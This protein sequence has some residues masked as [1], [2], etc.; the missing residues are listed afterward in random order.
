MKVLRRLASLIGFVVVVAAGAD[1]SACVLRAG[2]D[3]YG[4]YMYRDENGRETGADIELMRALADGAG[5]AIEFRELPWARLLRQIESGAIDLTASV[6][7]TTEREAYAHFSMPYRRTEMGVFV[8][9][10]E[11]RG[12]AFDDLRDIV[13][14]GFRLGVIQDYYYGDEFE[15]LRNDPAFAAH[16]D[17]SSD[18]PSI[19]RK[20]VHGRIDGL[21]ADDVGVMRAE[22]RQ[23]GMREFVERHPLPMPGDDLHVMFSRKSV[24]PAVVAAFDDAIARMRDDGRLRAILERFLK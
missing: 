4:L 15:A 18:Y 5:C 19:I 20:L 6:S 21:L 2:W 17:I 24:D 7:Y 11:S 8:R 3:P 22:A 1:A 12:W 9:T 10:A 14:T 23:L 13:E 16:L